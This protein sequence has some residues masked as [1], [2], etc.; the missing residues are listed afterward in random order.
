MAENKKIEVPELDFM[1]GEEI[2]D[3]IDEAVEFILK[4]TSKKPEICIVLGSGLGEY[5]SQLKDATIIPYENIPNFPKSTITG[6][7][8]R[9]CVGYIGKKCVAIMQGRIHYY[10]GY[11]TQIITFPIRV[12]KRIGVHSLI[13]TNACGGV[14][15]HL[16]PGDLMVI[17]NHIGF[18]CPSPLRG[19]PL[20]S[21]G[22]RFTDMSKPY[23][24]KYMELAR[25]SSIRQGIRL[26]RGV[27]G[28]APGPNYETAAE[29]RGLAVLGADVVGS[30]TVPETIVAVNCGMNVFGLSCITN[31]CCIH[32]TEVGGVISHEEVLEET[33]KAADKMANLL[34]D[35]ISQM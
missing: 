15:K 1:N 26:F 3:A 6:H 29:V 27:Y 13:L 11:D 5:V 31:K 12:M 32:T 28:Y 25:Q 34:N 30:S 16:E 17:E 33:S 20:P 4:K 21:F 10:E 8:G 2:M 18:F 23:T 7:P 14:S 35:I 24:P 9:L 19:A 22:P